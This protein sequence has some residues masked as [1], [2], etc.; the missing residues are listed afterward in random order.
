MAVDKHL[1]DLYGHIGVQ[2]SNNSLYLEMINDI[3]NIGSVSSNFNSCQ[4][5][6][7]YSSEP[8]LVLTILKIKNNHILVIGNLN[9]NSISNKLRI[10]NNLKLKETKICH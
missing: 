6:G 7:K 1:K 10:S 2:I 5:Y 9:I 4:D 8:K 3:G